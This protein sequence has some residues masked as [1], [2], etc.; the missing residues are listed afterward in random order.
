MPRLWSILTYLVAGIPAAVGI[1]FVARYAYVTSDT[2]I[3]G[4]SSA[5]LYGMIALAA[6][7]GPAAAIAVWANGWRL[8]AGI[9]GIIVLATMIANVS[10]TLAAIANRNAGTEAE[11]SKAETQSKLDQRRLKQIDLELEKLEVV[12]VSS[13]A[14]ATAAGALKAAESIRLSDCRDGRGPK[15]IAAESAEQVK[16]DALAKL[17]EK[18]AIS[19]QRSRLAAEATAI[20]EKLKT[21]EP[22]KDRDPLGRAL[23]NIL[24][25]PEEKASS[26]QH[27]LLSVIFE[28]VVAAVLSL[29]ELLRREGSVHYDQR[30]GIEIENETPTQAPGTNDATS[31]ARPGNVG[32]FVLACVPRADGHE[33]PVTSI[34]DRYRQWCQEQAPPARALEPTAFARQLKDIC[35]RV[36]IPT[37]MREGTAYMINVRLAGTSRSLLNFEHAAGPRQQA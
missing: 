24:S 31:V 35:T 34:Y 5:F 32:R 6:Y 21:A 7:G 14:V 20:R 33:A 17:S 13:E 19:D 16:R 23:S 18:Q 4:V 28:L 12:A 25:M 8:A 37:Q 22:V 29:P 11:R 3:D 10:Q 2:P 36:G 1:C 30:N 26:I 9:I 27:G 15:C